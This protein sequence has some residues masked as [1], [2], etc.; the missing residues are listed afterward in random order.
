[1]QKEAGG[2]R[3]AEVGA[4]EPARVACLHLDRA[5]ANTVVVIRGGREVGLLTVCVMAGRF[6]IVRVRVR[7][8]AYDRARR[9]E[10][11][12]DQGQARPVHF[13]PR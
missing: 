12:Q 5:V 1:M 13:E 8:A 11:D 3:L 10:A 2:E 9:H 7:R 6:V 4:I